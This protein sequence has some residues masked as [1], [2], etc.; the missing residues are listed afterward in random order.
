MLII[1]GRKSP[2]KITTSKVANSHAK[3]D[4]NLSAD[5]IL[6]EHVEI[7]ARNPMFIRSWIV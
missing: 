1:C 6:D 3:K 7:D 4:V 2:V 5:L